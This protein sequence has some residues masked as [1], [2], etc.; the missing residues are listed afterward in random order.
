MKYIALLASVV[1]LSAC[2]SIQ[3]TTPHFERVDR[4]PLGNE[5]TV[6]IGDTV[7]AKGKRYT[8]KGIHLISPLT[9]SSGI[10]LGYD[11]P[12]QKMPAVYEDEKYTYYSAQRMMQ[13]DLM[14]GAMPSAGGIC[15]SKDSPTE[16]LVY[17]QAGHCVWNV[18][19]EALIEP[20]T[21]VSETSPGFVQELIYNGRVDDFVKFLYR[22]FAQDIARPA[23]SQ[24]VQYDLDD[25]PIVGFKD[26]RIEIISATNT[27]LTYKVIQTF[28]DIE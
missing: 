21:V 12:A 18:T 16:I 25:G 2:S 26:A 13:K 11:I 6:N 14:L 7:V 15:I 24:E 20:T 8:F 19:D 17:V 10:T 5:V 3:P 22:E 4:P 1:A 27:E 9:K 28:P 23:F